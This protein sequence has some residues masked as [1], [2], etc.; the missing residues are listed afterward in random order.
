M[1][2]LWK[3]KDDRIKEFYDVQS[4]ITK[5]CAEISGTSEQ[6]ESPLVDE[7]DLSTK[8]LDGYRAQL[9]DLQKEKVRS[10]TCH[11]SAIFVTRAVFGSN[12]F[13]VVFFLDPAE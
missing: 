6:V 4:Q 3:Q 1:E 11:K 10:I 5:I 9:Q 7:S 13:M 8:K 12:I 2:K